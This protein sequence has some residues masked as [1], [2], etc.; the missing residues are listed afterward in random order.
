M[1]LIDRADELGLSVALRLP[2]E[3]SPRRHEETLF[4]AVL[5]DAV[6]LFPHS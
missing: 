4:L 2:D 3:P 6:E 5:E 1:V